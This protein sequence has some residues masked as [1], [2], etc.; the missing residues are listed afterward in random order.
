MEQFEW[1][2]HNRDLAQADI[3]RIKPRVIARG[4][5]QLA[6]QNL[7]KSLQGHF[8]TALLRWRR[9]ESPVSDM[10]QAQAKAHELNTAITAWQLSDQTLNGYGYVWSLVRYIAFLLGRKA[11]LPGDQL[12]RI[13][14]NQ[15]QYADIALDYHVLDA[16]EGREWREG[17]SEPF[18]RLASKKRQALAVATCQTY[19]ALLEPGHDKE[20]ID[21]L[22]REAEANYN[23]RAKDGFFGGGP[24][25]MGGGPDN[26]YVVDFVLAA[27]LKKIGWDGESVH[28]WQWPK[29][30]ERH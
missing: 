19:F 6:Y 17:L 16:L 23:R 12:P 30:T 10:E 9:G 13:Q 4:D 1:M 21:A 28:K 18:A 11:E 25:Y 14:K 26:P 15:S 29:N 3:A 8:D 5:F 24:T 22:V 27:I 20:R 7:A 2:I